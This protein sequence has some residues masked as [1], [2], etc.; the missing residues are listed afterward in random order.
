VPTGT[1]KYACI[2]CHNR[3]PIVD[4]EA[5][6]LEELRSYL[7]S[8]ERIGEYLAAAHS[9]INEKARLLETL[10][11]ELERVKTDAEKVFRLYMDDKITGDEFKEQNDPLYARRKQIEEEI[12]KAEAEVSLL[13]IDGLSSE[14]IREEAADLHSSWPSMTTVE[15]SNCW[16]NA[17]PSRKTKST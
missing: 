11:K 1:P 6:F 3:I 10:T 4:L 7:L 12:P 2:K 5:I 15:S 14:Y 8:P 13:K 9:T 16:Q 17:S